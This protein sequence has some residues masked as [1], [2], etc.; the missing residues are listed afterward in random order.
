[1]FWKGEDQTPAD[2]TDQAHD[3][4]HIL[5]CGQGTAAIGALVPAPTAPDEFRRF[6]SA[7]CFALMQLDRVP[8]HYATYADA[9]YPRRVNDWIDDVHSDEPFSVNLYAHGTTYDGEDNVGPSP[10]FRMPCRRRST[11]LMG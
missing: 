6:G 8:A 4:D 2:P 10:N 3:I 9:K 1:M 7:P 11:R 5:V